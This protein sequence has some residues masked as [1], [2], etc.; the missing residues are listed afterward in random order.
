MGLDPRISR[1][2][3]LAVQAFGRPRIERVG[4]LGRYHPWRNVPRPLV[5]LWDNAEEHYGFTST[6]FGILNRSAMS[7]AFRR[8]PMGR[9]ALLL[10]RLAAPLAARVFVDPGPEPKPK[11]RA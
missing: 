6:V 1:Y 4:D 2:M 3:Q 8:K 10:A 5:E 11:P 9:L 7:P